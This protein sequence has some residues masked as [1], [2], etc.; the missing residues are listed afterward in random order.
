MKLV[1]LRNSQDSTKRQ[2]GENTKRPDGSS[3]PRLAEL[4]RE[5]HFP[6]CRFPEI[7]G[8][9]KIQEMLLALY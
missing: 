5:N 7:P 3:L 4:G 9:Q 1:R 6:N 2:I 8:Q